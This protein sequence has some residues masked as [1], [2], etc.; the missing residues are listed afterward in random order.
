MKKWI[1]RNYKPIKNKKSKWRTI[2]KSG[3]VDTKDNNGNWKKEHNIVIEKH[4]GRKLKK[5]EVVHHIDHN[6]SNNN[7]ENLVLCESQ[8]DHQ[9]ADDVLTNPPNY[10]EYKI[11]K[12]R[13][14]KWKIIRSKY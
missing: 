12:S 9:T 3:Y 14:L 11:T 4:I 13:K 7:I 8:F 1:W 2:N 5:G 10:I 6:R